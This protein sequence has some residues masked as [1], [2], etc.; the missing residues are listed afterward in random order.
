MSARRNFT[1]LEDSRYIVDCGALKCD[2]HQAM[3]SLFQDACV[4]MLTEANWSQ[5]KFAIKA[6]ISESMVSK[7]T[8]QGE[9]PSRDVLGRI[10]GYLFGG[11]DEPDDIPQEKRRAFAAKLVQ[12]LWGDL[13]NDLMVPADLLTSTLQTG[14][15]SRECDVHG[16]CTRGQAFLGKLFDG[17][18][19][20]ILLALYSLGTAARDNKE[21]E[22]TLYSAAELANEFKR[23]AVTA[24]G[25]ARPQTGPAYPRGYFG[26]KLAR[27]SKTKIGIPHVGVQMFLL[28]FFDREEEP[29]HHS[30]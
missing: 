22:M 21:F 30:D 7:I 13:V 17:L 28:D 1:D 6:K 29:P 27:M 15:T 23:T 10:F 2:I 18:P 16:G 5:A 19:N 8:A 12:A 14:G 24:Y 25:G 11:G 9:T 4:A 20:P 26:N 3:A